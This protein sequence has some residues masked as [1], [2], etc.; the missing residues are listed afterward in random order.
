MR[1]LVDAQ[2]PYSLSS[3][4]NWRGMDAIH[5]DDLSGKEKTTDTEIRLISVE[6]NRIVISKDYDFVDSYFVSG[7]PAKLP[8]VSTGNIVNQKLLDIFSTNLE[9]ILELFEKHTM[10]ELDNFEVIV[11]E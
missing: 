5:T 8:W 1:F 6:Q 2:L 4:L 7:I 9:T 11:H 10:L 3:F